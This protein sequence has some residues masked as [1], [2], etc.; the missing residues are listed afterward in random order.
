MAKDTWKFNNDDHKK[1]AQEKIA[2]V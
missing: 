1:D 2:Q